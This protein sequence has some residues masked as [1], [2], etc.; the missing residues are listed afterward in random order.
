[1]L[2]KHKQA[3]KKKVKY[4]KDMRKYCDDQN[5]NKIELVVTTKEEVKEDV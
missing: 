3:L 1:M 5:A 2:G 4:K